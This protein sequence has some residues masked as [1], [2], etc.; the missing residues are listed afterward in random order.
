MEEDRYTLTEIKTASG[1]TLLKDPIEIAVNTTYTPGDLCGTLTAS[2]TVNG[3]SV[4]M[5]SQS[6]SDHALVPLT[7]LN[8]HGFTLPKTGGSGTT[9]TTVCGILVLAGVAG[10]VIYSKGKRRT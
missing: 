2:A 7:V 9:L 4:T 8:T 5:K 10:Y 1:Y 6:G 3:D